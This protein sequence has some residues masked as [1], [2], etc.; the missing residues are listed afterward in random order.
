MIIKA[1]WLRRLVREEDALELSEYALMSAL[2]TTGIVATIALIAG[3]ISGRFEA[4]LAVLT[5]AVG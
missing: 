4:L 2:V 5:D 3:F 1:D